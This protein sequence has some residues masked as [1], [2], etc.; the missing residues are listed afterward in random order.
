MTPAGTS[1]TASVAML[2]ISTRWYPPV[3]AYGRGKGRVDERLEE[4]AT[5]AKLRWDPANEIPV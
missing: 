3:T 4:E 1:L 2:T 5:E